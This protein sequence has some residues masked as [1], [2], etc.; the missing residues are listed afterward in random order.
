MGDTGKY[1]RGFRKKILRNSSEYLGDSGGN[2]RNS[3][4]HIKDSGENLLKNI[5]KG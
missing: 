3:G 5:W 1:L 2:L 4:K